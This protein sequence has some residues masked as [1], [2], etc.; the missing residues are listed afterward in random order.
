MLLFGGFFLLPCLRAPGRRVPGFLAG[1]ALA[2]AVFVFCIHDPDLGLLIVHQ[3]VSHVSF[4]QWASPQL[5]NHVQ[6]F[7]SHPTVLDIQDHVRFGVRGAP[8]WP[9]EELRKFCSDVLLAFGFGGVLCENCGRGSCANRSCENYIDVLLTCGFGGLLC[10]NCV[11][12]SCANRR[13]E[14]F[15]L[16]SCWHAGLAECCV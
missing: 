7:T 15:V 14:N 5:E 4:A 8:R 12:G 3:E 9:L 10:V 13:C 6:I 11:R 2:F 16:M 1:P